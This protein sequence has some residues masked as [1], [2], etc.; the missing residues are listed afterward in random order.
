MSRLKRTQRFTIFR[1]L[2]QLTLNEDQPNQEALLKLIPPQ[3]DVRRLQN[4]KI[5]LFDGKNWDWINKL[6]HQLNIGLFVY[7]NGKTNFQSAVQKTSSITGSQYANSLKHLVNLSQKLYQS[8]IADRKNQPYPSEE[9]IE[10]I[11]ELI[12]DIN[13]S[14]FVG[15]KLNL[16]S[17]IFNILTN[18][19]STAKI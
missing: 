4:I 11:E 1:K 7:S 5:Y 8:L 2:G 12:A 17:N 15:D 10:I 14:S 6:V 16:K 3:Q 13:S 9:I 18:W 19:L